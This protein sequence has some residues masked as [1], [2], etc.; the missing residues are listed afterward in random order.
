MTAELFLASGRKKVAVTAGYWRVG[1]HR[2]ERWHRHPSTSYFYFTAE[3]ES[4]EKLQLHWHQLF[5][6]PTKRTTYNRAVGC[7]V[8]SLLNSRENSN[9]S[10]HQLV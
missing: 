6:G 4:T 10:N 8:S 3:L 1:L 5:A 7:R 9:K 2:E